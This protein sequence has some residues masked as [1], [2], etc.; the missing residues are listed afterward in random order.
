MSARGEKLLSQPSVAAHGGQT[1]TDAVRE[2]LTPRG[3]LRSDAVALHQSVRLATGAA[4]TRSV[5]LH[6]G[7]KFV[8]QRAATHHTRTVL[9]L[10]AMFAAKAEEMAATECCEGEE[11]EADIGLKVPGIFKNKLLPSKESRDAAAAKA[12]ELRGKAAAAAKQGAVYAAGK[13]K[14]AARAAPGKLAA[15]AVEAYGKTRIAMDARAKKNAKLHKFDMKI[16]PI[17]AVAM[18]TPAP[19]MD[20][21]EEETPSLYATS[22]IAVLHKEHTKGKT[23][24]GSFKVRKGDQ[25]SEPLVVTPFGLKGPVVIPPTQTEIDLAR[26]KEKL[27]KYEAEGQSGKA[28]TKQA[29]VAKLQAQLD[30]ETEGAKAQDNCADR[31]GGGVYSKELIEAFSAQL[32]MVQGASVAGG[33]S[34]SNLSAILGFAM[35]H[36]PGTL[37]WGLDGEGMTTAIALEA[38]LA[39]LAKTKEEIRD[40][41][42]LEKDVPYMVEYGNRYPASAGSAASMKSIVAFVALPLPP[43][44]SMMLERFEGNFHR[45]PCYADDPNDP[46]RPIMKGKYHDGDSTIN[47]KP[48]QLRG[49]FSHVL[50]PV[51]VQTRD[52]K[53]NVSLQTAV[54]HWGCHPIFVPRDGYDKGAVDRAFRVDVMG[55][56]IVSE[57]FS[58]KPSLDLLN[59]RVVYGD[60]LKPMAEVGKET[61]PAHMDLLL[62]WSA[63]T[64]GHGI[65]NFSKTMIP[66]SDGTRKALKEL[67]AYS[68]GEPSDMPPGLKGLSEEEL[69]AFEHVRE[70]ERIVCCAEGEDLDPL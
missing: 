21:A 2:Q 10:D 8:P 37:P 35:C 41:P 70:A 1:A 16:F 39:R 32:K 44:D 9:D 56:R 67:L 54:V 26:K 36:R 4:P 68:T 61:P 69:D 17:P 42:V 15:G 6:A 55:E 12:A 5:P 53:S 22:I 38:E 18:G 64:L 28:K 7:P 31:S 58:G 25:L 23:N 49:A 62:A 52:D 30:A 40:G 63:M 59:Y 66:V 47:L 51:H 24:K 60:S 19:P 48:Q 3:P 11:E 33:E 27:A 46:N 57:G 50:Y 45:Q 65:N 14:G 43:S 34:V 13:V 29:E 20:K